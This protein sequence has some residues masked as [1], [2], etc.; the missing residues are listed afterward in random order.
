MLAA[1]SEGDADPSWTEIFE[2]RFRPLWDGLQS[3]LGQVEGPDTFNVYIQPPPV[4]SAI[5]SCHSNDG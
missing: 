5:M 1:I 2:S 3:A 4:G